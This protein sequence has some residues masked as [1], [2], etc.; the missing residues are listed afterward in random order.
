MVAVKQITTSIPGYRPVLEERETIITFDETQA[1]A[2]VYTFNPA[3]IRKLD[4][5]TDARSEEIK[6]IRAESINGVECREYE[7][8]KKWLKVNASRILDEE[9]RKAW[10]ERFQS[11]SEA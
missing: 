4:D 5:L 9:Q 3:L 7:L 6:C 2:A 11:K 1:P 8:P 10:A